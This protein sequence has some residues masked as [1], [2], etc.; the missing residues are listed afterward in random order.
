METKYFTQK[1]L[2]TEEADFGVGM[3][4][5]TTRGIYRDD[6][7]IFICHI[8]GEFLWYSDIKNTPKEECEGTFIEDCYLV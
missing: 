5:K 3:E 6:I 8:E 4:I 7:Q 1:N 2:K